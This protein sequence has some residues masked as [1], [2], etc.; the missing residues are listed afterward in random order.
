MSRMFKTVTKTWNPFT[1]CLHDCTYCWARKLV[2]ERLEPQGK[3][4]KDGF[5][6]TFHEGELSK[7]F[8][9]GDFVFVSDM[10]D[11]SFMP[12]FDQWC[13][14]L[15]VVKNHPHT[16]FLL[17]TKNPLVFVKGLNLEPN[18][19]IGAT[20][21]SNRD[22]GLT[23]A[24]APEQRYHAMCLIDYR[25]FLSVEPIMDFDLETLVRWIR[26]I[27]PE[28]V[29]VGADNYHNNLAEPPWEKVEALLKS[30]REFVPRVIE[31]DGLERLKES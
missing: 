3:K 18:I 1:G 31:K 21:E 17:Q 28:I 6:P 25:K 30:L 7:R 27:R 12:F 8:R 2:K 19:Y 23:K 13:K 11:I 26:D 4:Y 10:G 29:E 24:P 9:P 5:A 16:S 14:V 15:D 20:I 22:Y